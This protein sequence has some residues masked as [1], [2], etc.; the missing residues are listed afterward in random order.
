MRWLITALLLASGSATADRPVLRIAPAVDPLPA[1]ER[2]LGDEPVIGLAWL[3]ERRLLAVA[4]PTAIRLETP[5][6][7]GRGRRLPCPAPARILSFSAD[8][9]LLATLA[10]TAAALRLRVLRV[11]GGA[12][13]ADRLL[14]LPAGRP[15][16]IPDEPVRIMPA[17]D[18]LDWWLA[19]S[20]TLYRLSAD[21]GPVT[22][23]PAGLGPDVR[24]DQERQRL[25][26]VRSPGRHL[27]ALDHA[28]PTRVDLPCRPLDF[29]VAASED[30]VAAT[31]AGPGRSATVYV[32]RLSNGRVERRIQTTSATA[33]VVLTG[34]SS[35]L[36]LEHAPPVLQRVEADEVRIDALASRW[37][38]LSVSA[39]GTRLAGAEGFGALQVVD[40]ASG[41]PVCDH[42][43]VRPAQILGAGFGAGD[44]LWLLAAEAQGPRARTLLFQM[45]LPACAIESRTAI[46]FPVLAGAIPAWIPRA[47]AFAADLAAGEHAGAALVEVSGTPLPLYPKPRFSAGWVVAP[48]ED[49]FAIRHAG[50]AEVLE[51]ARPPRPLFPVPEADALVFCGHRIAVMSWRSG[52]R[53]LDSTGRRVL[54]TIEGI[55]SD[56]AD[57]R[58][59]LLAV[60]RPERLHLVDVRSL[61]PIATRRIPYRTVSALVITP[62]AHEVVLA[63]GPTGWS[64]VQIPPVRPARPE[65]APP[66]APIH[67]SPAGSAPRPRRGPG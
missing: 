12:V 43:A 61:T 46:N 57:C 39:D 35:A 37:E 3:P 38:Q 33:E 1:P 11:P 4:T 19:T 53:I 6:Q 65:A 8:G 16:G 14:A 63:A 42:T 45:T 58:G 7:W 52:W 26:E 23:D 22:P 60:V 27:V 34:A 48:D 62:D 50:Y 13:V 9:S 21:G 2:L 59:D 54:G 28:T 30:R 32:V 5:G 47:R 41:E 10:R 18:G 25:W 17:P 20:Q 36:I 64:A 66:E 40:R 67:R 55:D 24:M 51:L 15:T 29:V 44:A 31:C 49:R 56:V